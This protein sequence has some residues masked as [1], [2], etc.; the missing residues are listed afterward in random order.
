MKQIIIK[1]TIYLT[2]LVIVMY[3]SEKSLIIITTVIPINKKKNTQ[4]ITDSR[5]FTGN[6]NYNNNNNSNSK[7]I[8][9]K[10]GHMSIDKRKEVNK[11]NIKKINE[12]LMN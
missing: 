10:R 5:N 7:N 9:Q 2:I 3:I 8:M 12:N 1:I 6:S 11:L 4:H